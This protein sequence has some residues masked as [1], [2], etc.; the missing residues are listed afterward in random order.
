MLKSIVLSGK[1]LTP[2]EC[3][4]NILDVFEMSTPE[5]REE[6]KQWYIKANEMCFDVS[7]KYLMPEHQVVGILSALS[8]RTS[9]EINQRKLQEVLSKGTTFATGLQM[10]KVKRIFQTDFETTV[11]DI[12]NGDKTKN[13]YLNIRRPLSPK[14]V[15]IDTHAIR[16]AYK[17]FR[18]EISEP[19]MKPNQYRFFAEGY[20]SVASK[21]NLLPNQLQAITWVTI[22]S[23]Y[24]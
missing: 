20:T 5:Q 1:K 14:G 24:S 3:R 17:D 18:R 19:S 23:L 22:K 21:L 16:V 2:E 10:D 6:G 4:Q 15:T 11:L 13:F 7:M 9:W 12:L 8:P